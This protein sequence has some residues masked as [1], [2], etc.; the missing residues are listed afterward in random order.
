M[1]EEISRFAEETC[2]RKE[3]NQVGNCAQVEIAE[4]LASILKEKI[5]GIWY[6]DFVMLE[7]IDLIVVH[8]PLLKW[9]FLAYLHEF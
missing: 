5:Y 3:K 9:T 8:L 1:P 4:E 2:F 7:I 6:K